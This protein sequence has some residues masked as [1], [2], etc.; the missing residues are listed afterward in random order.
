[1]TNLENNAKK[2]NSRY[3]YK[4]ELRIVKE[5]KN[6]QKVSSNTAFLR[7]YLCQDSLFTM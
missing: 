7:V 2:T 1:M 3:Y 6:V 4:R 5:S